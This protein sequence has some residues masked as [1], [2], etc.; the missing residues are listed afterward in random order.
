[1]MDKRLQELFGRA[2]LP[3]DDFETQLM[4]FL[5]PWIALVSLDKVI[6]GL[7]HT[8]QTLELRRDLEIEAKATPPSRNR[9]P[10]Q[11]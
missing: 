5:H 3:K 11:D 4:L 8:V 2:E 10:E 1:M 6:E 9:P 7:D